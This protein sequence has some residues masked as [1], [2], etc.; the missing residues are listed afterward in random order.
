MKR[1][2]CNLALFVPLALILLLEGCD[3]WSDSHLYGEIT[4]FCFYNKSKD[5]IQIISKI[6]TYPNED[7]SIVRAE[8]FYKYE[9]SRYCYQ[10]APN[11]SVILTVF[12]EIMAELKRT[13]QI[14]VLRQTTLNNNTQDEII[15]NNKYDKLYVL[16]YQDFVSANFKLYYTDDEYGQQ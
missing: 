15:N 7:D 9:Q 16:N 1:P 5:T 13:H 12:V 8:H 10:L 2:R 6:W 3:I 4:D 14:M 11:D